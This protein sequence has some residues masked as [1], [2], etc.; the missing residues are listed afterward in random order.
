[1]KHL[2]IIGL[3]VPEAQSTAAGFRMM[4]LMDL[5]KKWEYTI[6]FLT[7]ATPS[8]FS[9]NMDVI[10]IQL[11]HENFDDQ[12]KELRPDVVLFDRFV[13]EEQFGWRVAEVCPKA[14]RILDTEDLH[15]LREAR[16][17]SFSEQREVKHSDLVNTVFKREMASILR[18]DLSLVISRYEF[19][20]LTEHFKIDAEILFYLPFLYDGISPVSNGFSERKHF[21]SIGNFLHEPN[22]QTVLQLKNLW[23]SLRKK[24]PNA[25]L[26]IYGAYPSEKVFQLH[27]ESQGFMVKGRAMDKTEVFSSYRVLL[28]PIPYGAGLKGKLFESMVFGL[29]NVTSTMGA[30][31]LRQDSLWNGFVTELNEDFVSKAVQLYQDEETWNK[32]QQNG[33]EILNT[34]FSISDF[35]I[36]LFQK[37]EL[38]ISHLDDHRSQH[39]LGQILNHHLLQSTKYM[40]KWIEE[41][42]KKTE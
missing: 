24:L 35:E 4:Q 30:E 40:S 13:T 1:M 14:L 39:F 36:T 20:L 34:Y 25:E 33:Y 11:N 29:P 42:N 2:V 19:Q 41:K 5:F 9:E 15:F 22:W 32:A 26:H 23:P 28:A 12:I 21:M 7:S 16:R 10:A 38:T 31:G 8:D 17:K 27:N 18:S 6:S 37:I 3:V